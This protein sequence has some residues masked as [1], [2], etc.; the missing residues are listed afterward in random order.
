MASVGLQ[1]TVVP[2]IA[3]PSD[4][5]ALTGCALEV[6]V[7]LGLRKQARCCARFGMGCPDNALPDCLAGQLVLQVVRT[8]FSAFCS[9]RC[10]KV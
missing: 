3:Q 8:S 5:E 2:R 9:F 10:L 4:S 7:D 1:T 6:H